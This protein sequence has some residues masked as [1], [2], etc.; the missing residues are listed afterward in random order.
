MVLEWDGR[1]HLLR[2][3]V[4]RKYYERRGAFATRGAGRRQHFPHVMTKPGVTAS[5]SFVAAAEGEPRLPGNGE[6]IRIRALAR[7]PHTAQPAPRRAR[8]SMTQ[9]PDRLR[10]EVS[11][12]T[13]R[14]WRRASV[15]CSPASLRVRSCGSRIAVLPR[16]EVA[17]PASA[18]SAV[19]APRR[20]AERAPPCRS[21]Y[22]P[23]QVARQ[24][25][26][27]LS[28]CLGGKP[29]DIQACKV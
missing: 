14:S 10:D 4:L 15:R 6:S 8:N 27:D 3:R 16:E 12:G 11:A 23:I 9:I 26:Y 21:D 7:S 22:R 13:T 17:L 25:L 1:H 24:L 28:C 5:T 2:R 18:G 29:R 20:T 19:R